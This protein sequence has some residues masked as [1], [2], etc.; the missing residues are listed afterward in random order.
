MLQPPFQIVAAG[1]L[2]QGL[3]AGARAPHVVGATALKAGGGAGEWQITV[4]DPSCDSHNTALVLSPGGGSNLAGG[5]SFGQSTQSTNAAGLLL[6][7]FDTYR[8]DTNAA[9]D[10][11]VH[12]MVVKWPAPEEGTI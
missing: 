10:V 8:N 7:L 9:I 3:S 1:I 6:L 11:E 4:N 12:F 2:P 5:V